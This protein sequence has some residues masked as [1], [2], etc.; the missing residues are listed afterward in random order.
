MNNHNFTTSLLVDQSPMEVFNAINNV[1]EWWSGNIQGDT[2]ALDDEFT[3]RM[4]DIHFSK[5]KLT[6]VIPGK[7]VVWLITDSSLNF[8]K[9]KTEWTGTKIIFDI[10]RTGG[11]TKL[12]FTQEGLVPELEC[13]DACSSAWTDYVQ[14]SLC[15]LITSGKTISDPELA[16]R[17]VAD[18]FRELAK[19]EKWFGIQEELFADNIKSIDPPGSPYMGYAEG[20]ADVLRKGQ[21]FVRGITAVHKLSTSA[22]IVAGAHFAVTREMD[23]TTEAHG[24]IRINQIMLYEVANGEI[25][26]EQFFYRP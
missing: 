3:Y 25:I 20:R 8:I 21:D 11:R 19:E 6:E 15:D 1:R 7:K 24:R 22:P 26:S 10:S 16:T 2:K 13:Y 5:H 12:V 18:R 9:D 4:K 17:Q 14:N 23:L